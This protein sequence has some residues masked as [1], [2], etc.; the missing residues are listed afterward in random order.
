MKRIRI[1]KE[2]PL[3]LRTC[4]ICNKTF[5]N[6]TSL[7]AH[8][9]G[10]H[11]LKSKNYYDNYLKT[12]EE[13]KCICCGKPTTY[14]NFHY[15]K[16]CS[17]KCKNIIY[18]SDENNIKQHKKSYTKKVRKKLSKKRIKYF[19]KQENRDKLSNTVKNYFKNPL[20]REKTSKAVSLSIKNGKQKVIYEYDNMKFQ[21]YYELSFYV[22]LKDHKIRFEYLQNKVSIQYNYNN[23]IYYYF[24]D[25]KVFNTL[26][27][28]KG[29]HFFD[30]NGKMINPFDR[31]QDGKYEAKHQCMINN[32]VHIIINCD[33]YINYVECKYGKTFKQNYIYKKDSQ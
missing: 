12:P 19:S 20:N 23:S 15:H 27:E 8:I 11:K 13:G 25:F 17:N 6:L 7:A 18:Y 32:Q 22:Y 9:F 3:Y 16:F 4:K 29:P 1:H 31:S 5:D 33:V 10:T 2:Y 28:I 24:P 30:N 14:R 26:V 21:S